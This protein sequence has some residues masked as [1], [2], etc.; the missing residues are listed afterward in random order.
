MSERGCL[1]GIRRHT[2]IIHTVYLK[3]DDE[4]G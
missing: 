2:I 1:T 4:D 3:Y